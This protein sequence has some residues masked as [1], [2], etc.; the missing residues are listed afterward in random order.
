LELGNINVQKEFNFA[1]DVVEA[2]WRLV[3]QET[4]FEAVIGS[5]ITYSIRDWLIYCFRKV[6]RDWEEYVFQN[7]AY[8]PEYQILISDPALIKS[9]GWSAKT[10]FYQLA[11]MMMEN[12]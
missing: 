1:G 2:I 10:N 11:D 6:N 5:G 12:F 7:D 3:N 8:I 4:I 9:L